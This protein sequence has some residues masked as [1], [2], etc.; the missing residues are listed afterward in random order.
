MIF[1]S[2]FV[3]IFVLCLQKFLI[4]PYYLRRSKQ[5]ALEEEKESSAQ[6]RVI[7]VPKTDIDFYYY[8]KSLFLICNFYTPHVKHRI[9]YLSCDKNDHMFSFNNSRSAS[10]Q[11]MTRFLCDCMRAPQPSHSNNHLRVE[12]ETARCD[13]RRLVC[14]TID[15]GESF[16][17]FSNLLCGIVNGCN[18]QLSSSY[19]SE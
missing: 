4:K 8:C 1:P 15:C 17:I 19:S 13:I 7:N 16:M 10:C 2:S 6:V 14:L 11:C 5:K 18:M 3:V 12:L 9:I